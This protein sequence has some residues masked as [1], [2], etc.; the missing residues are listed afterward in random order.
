MTIGKFLPALLL[1][2]WVS[3]SP[4][5]AGLFSDDEAH[6]KIAE[7]QRQLA[8]AR[9]QNAA[10]EQR[11][12]ALENAMRG[13]GTELL[14][15]VETLKNEVRRLNGLVETNTFNIDSAQKRQ[16]DLYVDL[17][18]RMRLIEKPTETVTPPL[19]QPALGT[20]PSGLPPLAPARGAKTTKA[21]PQNEGKA[22][23]AAF[24][25]FKSGNY[26][27]AIAAFNEFLAAYPGSSYA[28][29]A[30]YWIGNALYAQ[31]DYAG[32]IAAQRRLLSAYPASP[33]ASEALFNIASSQQEMG[34]MNG[35][36]KTLEDLVAKYPLSPAA[37][38]AK[39]RL[40]YLR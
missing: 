40:S 21:S 18:T 8:D 37:D 3:L 5:H 9:V 15:Q 12:A 16:K 24:Q 2:C 19:D 14:S 32:A 39:K 28:A 23:D 13:Q 35:A 11:V 38:L 27:N 10:L 17:D 26:P 7:L 29:N 36:R 20:P 22:Y 30:Q 4:A 25:L 31:R 1:G 6:R 34:D 33:K